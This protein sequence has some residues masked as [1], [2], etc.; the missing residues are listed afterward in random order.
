MKTS[1]RAAS[2]A[3]SCAVLLWGTILPAAARAEI[4][5]QPKARKFS[6]G[7][8]VSESYTTFVDT[9]ANGN[10]GLAIALIVL[11]VLAVAAI[12][13]AV[14]LVRSRKIHYLI[15]CDSGPLKGQ[16]F[17]LREGTVTIGRNPDSNIC[18]PNETKGISRA[19]C[20]VS[21][22]KGALT[23]QDQG[24]NSGTFILK[25]GQVPSD[26]PMSIHAGQS[27]YLG[28]QQNMFTIIHK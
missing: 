15:R 13:T 18:F 8:R 11:A 7:T 19:H 1:T 27:F 14:L 2:A 26:K 16:I 25:K 21:Y 5:N 10:N 17:P 20:I 22:K 6:L 12:V 28:Q 3:A 9:A 24:S 23:I 4:T